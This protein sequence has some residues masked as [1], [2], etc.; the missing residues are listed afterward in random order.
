MKR[1]LAVRVMIVGLLVSFIGNFSLLA[2]QKQP[3]TLD[4][5]KLD[6]VLKVVGTKF[7]AG[8]VVK[9][10]P[11]SATAV[12]ESTQTLGDGNQ[13]IQRSETRMYR[14][15]EG[16]TRDEGQMDTIGK[17]KSS[18]DVQVVFINDPVSGF[19]YTLNPN[20]RTAFKYNVYLPFEYLKNEMVDKKMAAEKMKQIVPDVVEGKKIPTRNEPPSKVAVGGPL[21]DTPADVVKK[22]I[23]DNR[24]G[25]DLG[26]QMIEGVQAQGKRTTMTIPAG[27]IGNMLPIEVVDETWYSPE[28]QTTIMTRHSD[29]RTGE[30]IYRLTNISRSEPDRSLFEIPA[31]YAVKEEIK[32]KVIKED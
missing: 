30:R 5:V 8:K 28:L 25:E 23:A 3:P 16:R 9:G 1:K 18:D 15:S 7:A 32:K 21:Q 11:F 17:W 2:Q 26:T 10:A 12:T 29:P 22:K 31:D 6:D 24:K 4:K 20:D 27:E 13:I 19:T 14:D